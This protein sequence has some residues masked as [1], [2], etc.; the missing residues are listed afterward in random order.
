M[1]KV[2]ELVRGRRPHLYPGSRTPGPALSPVLVP[3]RMSPPSEAAGQHPSPGC[4]CRGPAPSAAPVSRGPQ[5]GVAC[6]HD[7]PRPP[8]W[9]W[10][11]PLS[12]V[13]PFLERQRVGIMWYM[14]I[15]DWINLP[16]ITHVGFLHVFSWLVA[17]F[18]SALSNILLS[19]CFAIYPL[20]R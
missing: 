4:A 10:L 13:L 15:P 1:P 6:W 5:W 11:K 3:S 20:A 9:S 14:V 18:F 16:R 2:T 17:H 8:C 19:G 12:R 7:R